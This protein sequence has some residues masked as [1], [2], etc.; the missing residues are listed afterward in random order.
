M[1]RQPKGFWESLRFEQKAWHGP[2]GDW[3]L[4]DDPTENTPLVRVRCAACGRK[5]IG[6]AFLLNDEV[7]VAMRP[8]DVGHRLATVRG[9]R[10]AV[11]CS[12][13]MTTTVAADTI[14][15]KVAEAKRTGRVQSVRVGPIT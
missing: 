9:Q 12:C 4:V 6:G 5:E 13:S 15:V 8:D 3:H 7:W 11:T 2:V 10:L 14:M 1:T